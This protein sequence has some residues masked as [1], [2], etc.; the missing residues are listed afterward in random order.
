MI[1]RYVIHTVGPVY[2]ESKEDR[3]ASLLASCY[4]RSLEL[5]SEHHLKSIVSVFVIVDR[6]YT[7]TIMS[8]LPVYFNR[9]LRLS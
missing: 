4:R 8:G 1:S 2:S 7:I 9:H 3:V 5:A 6:N